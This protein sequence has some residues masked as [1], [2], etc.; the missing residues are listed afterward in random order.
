MAALCS[1]D[2]G[3]AFDGSGSDHAL[4]WFRRL[5]W[6]GIAAIFAII[7]RFGGAAFV[8]LIG[9]GYILFGLL[10]LAFGLPHALVLRRTQRHR[11]G[12]QP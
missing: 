6:S 2:F 9:G 5:V 10:D 12:A 8:S 11:R 3:A 1:V 7:R 4:A